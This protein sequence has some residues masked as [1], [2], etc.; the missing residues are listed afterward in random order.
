MPSKLR[1]SAA[2]LIIIAA[3]ALVWFGV[4]RH[5]PSTS[6]A[7]R[8]LVAFNAN[9]FGRDATD[10]GTTGSGQSESQ[11]LAILDYSLEKLQEVYYKPVDVALLVSGEQKGIATYLKSKHIAAQ[12]AAPVATGSADEETA[13]NVLR[14][15]FA[16][17]GAKF[18]DDDLT[19]AAIAGMLDSL[20]DPYT[21][22]LDPH[23]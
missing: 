19:W 8:L 21:V 14:T 3:F 18:G 16:S 1:F 20:G 9:G 6:T 12:P 13:N 4:V 17:Y 7:H 11:D 15:A 5:A 10:N 2:I 22:F 23:E